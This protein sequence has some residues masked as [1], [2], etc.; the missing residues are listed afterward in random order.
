M[1]HVSSSAT[2]AAGS[3]AAPVADFFFFFLDGAGSETGS[4]AAAARSSSGAARG[5][6]TA[7]S[8]SASED[9]R[10]NSAP[11]LVLAAGAS[12]ALA[13]AHSTTCVNTGTNEV[14]VSCNE[15]VTKA[16]TAAPSTSSIAAAGHFPLGGSRRT[17]S[18]RSKRVTSAPRCD[19]AGGSVDAAVA[20]MPSADLAA[21]A[22]PAP[23]DARHESYASAS[24]LSSRRWGTRLATIVR[25]AA[26][27]CAAWNADDSLSSASSVV[28]VSSPSPPMGGT[29]AGESN[30]RS[31]SGRYGLTNC[32]S[33]SMR[34]STA[35]S[36]ATSTAPSSSR[37]PAAAF[38]AAAAA[39]SSV[40]ASS[41]AA[42]AAAVLASASDTAAALAVSR[43]LG[44][45]AGR[46]PTDRTPCD[47]M[48]AA[49]HPAPAATTAR[50]E[51]ASDSTAA[52]A[53]SM[54][55]LCAF[56]TPENLDAAASSAASAA[57]RVA[58]APAPA[59]SASFSIS[60]TPASTSSARSSSISSASASSSSVDLAPFLA[61]FH[62][63]SL[64]RALLRA[65]LD[66]SPFRFSYLFALD[67]YAAAAAW[68]LCAMRRSALRRT[69]PSSCSS[70]GASALR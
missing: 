55:G 32:A 14:S 39:S 10:R 53:A 25:S 3:T 16:D 56:A 46:I 69:R 41:A 31:M 42:F 58:L 34:V 17:S 19:G 4:S 5:T 37:A 15:N 13:L 67:A 54:I 49:T 47:L 21:A 7:R 65:S 9:A 45:A 29:S 44:T 2:I 48:I 30:S 1:R 43:S 52:G 24:G 33:V 26:A 38:A 60:A 27:D 70:K 11:S 51:H 23:P 18:A 57:D 68:S 59:S 62:L 22:P 64:A 8:A 40:S 35:L 36:D 20:A 61:P 28:S 12:A 63:R 66:F 6:N 50:E